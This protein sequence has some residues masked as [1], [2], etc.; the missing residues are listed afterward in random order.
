MPRLVSAGLAL[1]LWAV[2]AGAAD[3]PRIEPLSNPQSQSIGRKV[4]PGL[5]GVYVPLFDPCPGERAPAPAAVS[6]PAP[7][8]ARSPSRPMLPPY[9]AVTPMQHEAAAQFQRGIEARARRDWGAAFKS[10]HEACMGSNY[11]RGCGAAVDVWDTHRDDARRALPNPVS[12]AFLAIDGCGA[13]DVLACFTLCAGSV[14]RTAGERPVDAAMVRRQ[15]MDRIQPA[16]VEAVASYSRA[17]MA[18]ARFARSAPAPAPPPPVPAAALSPAPPPMSVPSAMPPQATAPKP[19]PTAA[20]LLADYKKQGFM[21]PASLQAVLRLEPDHPEALYLLANAYTS[22]GLSPD[23]AVAS[24]QRATAL[25]PDRA[26][27]WRGLGIALARSKRWGEA[28]PA[29]QKSV[30]LDPSDETAWKELLDVHDT[31]GFK[32]GD[33]KGLMNRA[34]QR[35]PEKA[36]LWRLRGEAA[37]RRN[38]RAL[39]LDSYQRSAALDPKDLVTQMELGR[40]ACDAR[41]RQDAVHA[42]EAALELKPEHSTLFI[43][44]NQCRFRLGLAELPGN[45]PRATAARP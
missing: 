14:E 4:C 23:Q 6:G 45:R 13:G 40:L 39:A 42:F 3:P 44:Y 38:E 21:N 35:Y 24:A 11:K 5:P 32:A 25:E 9:E 29:L 26:L 17:R 34:V 1:L 22:M 7:S 31:W 16:E 41:R 33:P 27:Y 12:P 18:E 19:P 28:M 8:T 15:C 43:E 10:F 36:F 20:S 30:D 2:A 37:K